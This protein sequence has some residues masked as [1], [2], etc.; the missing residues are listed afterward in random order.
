MSLLLSRTP[1]SV[2]I[3]LTP[4]MI[5]SSS[6]NVID[7]VSSVEQDVLSEESS[8][9]GITYKVMSGAANVFLMTSSTRSSLLPNDDSKLSSGLSVWV[10]VV[11]VYRWRLRH[12]WQG[13][14]LDFDRVPLCNDVIDDVEEVQPKLPPRSP[15]LVSDSQTEVFLGVFWRFLGLCTPALPLARHGLL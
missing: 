10:P 5:T 15:F 12:V 4:S 2:W 1:H 13:W 9:C 7:D 3:A 8:P 11:F 6:S 14:I